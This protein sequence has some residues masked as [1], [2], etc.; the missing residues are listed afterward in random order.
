MNTKLKYVYLS[1][2]KLCMELSSYP[3]ELKLR[4]RNNDKSENAIQGQ[5]QKHKCTEWQNVRFL[6]L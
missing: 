3:T 4:V 2:S 6:T 5:H 1:Q